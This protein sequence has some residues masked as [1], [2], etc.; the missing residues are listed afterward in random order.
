[1]EHTT[2]LIWSLQTNYGESESIFIRMQKTA[3]EMLSSA[4]ITAHIQITEKLPALHIEPQ[5]N[6]SLIFK[7][8][9]NNVCK[10]SQAATCQVSVAPV[11]QQLVMR[12]SDD[13]VGIRNPKSGNGLK[14]MRS[15]AAAMEG[16]CLIESNGRG[17][18][19]TAILPV[20]K[21][22]AHKVDQE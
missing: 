17:T 11:D 14:N 12:I 6:C 16:E 8:A 10:Y 3:M 21:I 22:I 4:S 9:I 2:D 15:R 18:T 1:M 19:V 5:K 13:G 7:E 20:E